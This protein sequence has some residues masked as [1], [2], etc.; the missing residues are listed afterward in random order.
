MK[1]ARL[2]SPPPPSPASLDA[3][4]LGS[5]ADYLALI[6]PRVVAMI[7]LVTVAGFILGSPGSIRSLDWLLLARTLFGTALVAGGTLAL[8]MYLERDIDARMRRTLKRPLPSGRMQPMEAL[9]FGCALTGAGLL[10]LMLAVGP[11]SSLI[12]SLTVIS[13]LFMY[14]PMKRHTALCTV[15]GAFPGALP[16]ITGWVAAGGVL[17]VRAAVV[18]GILFFWQLPHSLA[19]AH[20]Y[21]EDYDRAGVKL[22]PTVDRAGGSTGRQ[23]VLN[24]LALMAVAM[25]PTVLGMTGWISFVVGVAA[26]GWLLWEGMALAFY[27]TTTQARRLLMASYAYI[28]AVLITMAIDKVVK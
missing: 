12:T 9:A 14:T 22:L 23:T 26:G 15:V 6:K 19:I 24:C 17:G 28:P 11:V 16:P 10:Y 13:Y 21:R 7:L 20:L 1:Q 2:G 3:L 25:L 27:D 8:N 18:F 5:A 4:T